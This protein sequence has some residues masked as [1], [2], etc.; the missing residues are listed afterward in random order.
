MWLEAWVVRTWGADGEGMQGAI[1]VGRACSLKETEYRA[2]RA[3]LQKH[4]TN[5]RRAPSPDPVE[6]AARRD[7]YLKLGLTVA[8]AGPMERERFLLE[9]GVLVVAV[10]PEGAASKAGLRA[11]DVIWRSRGGEGAPEVLMDEIEAAEL[12]ERWAEGRAEGTRLEI[13]REDR[14]E[15]ISLGR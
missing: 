10:A 14:I 6:I 12:A 11:G 7:L 9:S 15:I 13:V 4:S 5:R 2:L 3:D 1:E 8:A